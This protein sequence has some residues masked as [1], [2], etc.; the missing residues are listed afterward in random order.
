[1][2]DPF[3]DQLPDIDPEET[4]E[5]LE[6]LDQ[7]ID[8]SPARARF[9]LSR[10]MHHARARQIGLPAMVSS[11]YINTISPEEEPFFPGNEELELK[12]RQMIRWNAAVMVSRA[13]K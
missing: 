12:I 1:M 10:I 5:W 8:V 13:N 9:L 7:V 3:R 11:N 6:A 2:Y 4:G